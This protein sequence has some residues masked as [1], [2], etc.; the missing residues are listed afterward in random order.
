MGIE[1]KK[2]ERAPSDVAAGEYEESNRY[3]RVQVLYEGETPET[4]P[5]CADSV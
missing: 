1:G 2:E 4:R 5:M 3:P